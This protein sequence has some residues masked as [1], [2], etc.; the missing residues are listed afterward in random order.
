MRILQY[1]IMDCYRCFCKNR[2]AKAYRPAPSATA[3]SASCKKRCCACCLRAP[4]HGPAAQPVKVSIL[5]FHISP[6]HV[7]ALTSATMVLVYDRA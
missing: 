3:V 6:E 4:C 2:E 7:S 5:S 1:R